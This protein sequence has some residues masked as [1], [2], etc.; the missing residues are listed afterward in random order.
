MAWCRITGRKYEWQIDR[1]STPGQRKSYER[2]DQDQRAHAVPKT[3][4][5][6]T[7][8]KAA[9]GIARFT[10]SEKHDADELHNSTPRPTSPRRQAD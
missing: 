4:P 10:A 3:A 9:R 2:Q 6:A 1:D 7:T 5:R 8:G